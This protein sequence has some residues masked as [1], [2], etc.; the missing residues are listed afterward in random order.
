M[1]APQLMQNWLPAAWTWLH[2][3]QRA[4]AS[5]FVPQRVQ[6]R[7]PGSFGKPQ[8]VQGIFDIGPP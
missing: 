6:K 4:R 3:G 7:V 5:R 2:V 1:P 8:L